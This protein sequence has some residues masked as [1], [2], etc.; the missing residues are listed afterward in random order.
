MLEG[1]RTRGDLRTDNDSK[2]TR[3]RWVA[4]DTQFSSIRIKPPDRCSLRRFSHVGNGRAFWHVQDEF[5]KFTLGRTNCNIMNPFN[6]A[7]G[8]HIELCEFCVKYWFLVFHI[9]T[10]RFPRE[11]GIVDWRQNE[12]SNS[13]AAVYGALDRN[14]LGRDHVHIEIHN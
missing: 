8:W 11:P 7:G 4:R 1:K 10:A 2:R 5:P 3:L 6:Y 12:L 9:A 13:I 14:C